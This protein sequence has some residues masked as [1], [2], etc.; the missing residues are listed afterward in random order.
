LPQAISLDTIKV[1][2]NHG[3]EEVKPRPFENSLAQKIGGFLRAI[4]AALNR[5]WVLQS[6]LRVAV[7]VGFQIKRQ[8]RFQL[9]S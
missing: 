6:P 5:R 2:A 8:G 3:I 1:H 9:R 7:V 4:S